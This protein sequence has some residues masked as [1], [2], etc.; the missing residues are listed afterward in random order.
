MAFAL[1]QW[2]SARSPV[3][4]KM[5]MTRPYQGVSIIIKGTSIG[6]TSDID[7]NYS[8]TVSDEATDLIFNYIGYEAITVAINGQSVINVVM[9]NVTELQE[10]VVSALGFT[11]KRDRAGSTSSSISSNAIRTSGETGILNSLAGKAAGVKIAR[12][13][14][15]PG[16]GTSI[17][18]RV[19]IRSEDPPSRLSS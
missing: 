13:N 12:A 3:R 16:A 5:P 6:T 4:S 2:H 1:F 9:N 15:D 18:I 19:P 17:Q 14:G 10:V 8:L 7:G 11:S